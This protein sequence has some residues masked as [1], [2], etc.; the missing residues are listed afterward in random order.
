MAWT[1]TCMGDSKF[2]LDSFGS[3]QGP[4]AGACEHDSR[5]LGS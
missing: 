1:V 4:V 3:G 2:I 5:L